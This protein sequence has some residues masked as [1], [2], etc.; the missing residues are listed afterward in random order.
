DSVRT[1]LKHREGWLAENA[2]RSL[3]VLDYSV[4][5]ASGEVLAGDVGTNRLRFYDVLG[6][7]VNVAFRLVGISTDRHCSHLVTAEAYEDARS[8][9][10]GIEVD[11]VELGGKR[12]RLYRLEL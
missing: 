1:T 9:P 6:E 3:P 12:I 2:A 10:P 5:V 7:P 8:R 11:P 4:A